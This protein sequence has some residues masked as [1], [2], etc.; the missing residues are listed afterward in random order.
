[1]RKF[2]IRL[3]DHV[4]PSI[5]PSIFGTGV[6]ATVHA[7]NGASTGRITMTDPVDHKKSAVPEKAKSGK[8]GDAPMEDEE[9]IMAGRHDVNYPALLTKDVPGG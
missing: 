7:P 1:V 6:A 3:P 2:R 4:Y 5:I 9:K 8:E